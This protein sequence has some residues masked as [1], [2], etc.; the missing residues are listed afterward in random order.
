[1]YV[2]MY[3]CVS[4]FSVQ[5]TGDKNHGDD[6]R[7]P[8]F[9]QFL[10]CVWQLMDQFP[11]AFEFNEH[12]LITILDHLFRLVTH[13]L[14]HSLAAVKPVYSGPRNSGLYREVASLCMGRTVWGVTKYGLYKE[15]ACQCSGHYRQVSLYCSTCTDSDLQPL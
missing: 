9:L 3:V 8:I 6:Q 5:V 1:M 13:S 2:Y 15:V 12:F 10:D 14:T 4:L 11:T 7:A